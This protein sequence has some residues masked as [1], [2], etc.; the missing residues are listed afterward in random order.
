MAAETTTS[1]RLTFW[2]NG[3]EEKEKK[4]IDCSSNFTWGEIIRNSI[5]PEF[6]INTKVHK[7]RL[8]CRGEE[9]D[10]TSYPNIAKLEKL[11]YE[12]MLKG[13]F[14]VIIWNPTQVAPPVPPE[15]VYPE[16]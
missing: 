10:H 9:L 7:I 2:F 5:A 4:A 14:V 12:G 6:G 15:Q 11:L 1:V 13:I 3:T 16:L 8:V